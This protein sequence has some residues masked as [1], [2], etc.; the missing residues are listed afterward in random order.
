MT[1]DQKIQVW[2]AVGTW[3]AGVATFL[4]VLVSLYLARKGDAVNIKANVGVRLVFAGDGSD[5]EE[6][7]GFGIVNL[8]YRP[9]NVV[10]IGWSV[11]KG[12]SKRFCMQ[13]V[14]GQYTHQYPKV[15]AHGEQALFMV[16]FKAAPNW[17]KEFA[18]GFIED[19]GEQNFKTL[20]AQINTSIGKAI[21]VVPEK[22]LLERLRVAS[23]G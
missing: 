16:S 9:V 21:E 18:M 22:S 6:H 3:L 11:G 1:F 23:A 2:N 5:A 14:A 20:R 19:V 12:K 4:A 7:V 13:S 10:S 17:P 15:L 8:G